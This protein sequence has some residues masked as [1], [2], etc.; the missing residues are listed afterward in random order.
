MQVREATRQRDE[1][2]ERADSTQQAF[3]DAVD[4]LRSEGLDSLIKVLERSG[5]KDL[6]IQ[7]KKRKKTIEQKQKKKKIEHEQENEIYMA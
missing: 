2:I 5:R 7:T 3:L 4:R 1:A 6:A